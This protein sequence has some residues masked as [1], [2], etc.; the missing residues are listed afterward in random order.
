MLPLRPGYGRSPL[1]AALDACDRPYRGL[2]MAGRPY[3]GPGYGHPPPFLTAF[4][5]K[6]QQV[7]V[8][9]FYAIQSH[10]T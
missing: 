1:L 5:T 7:C 2:A 3:R 9:R 10:H 6:M 8:E 4:A